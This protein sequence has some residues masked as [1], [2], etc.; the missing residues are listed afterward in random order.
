MKCTRCGTNVD[1]D[2]EGNRLQ[3]IVSCDCDLT[4]F[5]QAWKHARDNDELIVVV[6]DFT[7]MDMV[8]EIAK[9][10]GG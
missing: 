7:V 10:M 6:G 1:R 3:V 2:E 5:D 4:V 8:E 9:R